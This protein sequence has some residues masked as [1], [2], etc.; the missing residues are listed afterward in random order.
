MNKTTLFLHIP[1]TGGTTLRDI[2]ESQYDDEKIFE[3]THFKNAFDQVKKVDNIEEYDIIKGHFPFG[4]HE[5]IDGDTQYI[6]FLRNPVKRI[7]SIYRYSLQHEHHH[8]YDYN[9]THSFLDYVKSGRNI[10][11][12][13]GHTRLLAGEYFSGDK[14]HYG[15]NPEWLLEKAFSNIETYFSFIGITDEFNKSIV[16]L[17]KKLKWKT[18]YYSKA[19]KSKPTVKANFNK[20]EIMALNEIN[21]LD[22]ALYSHFNKKLIDRINS[23]SNLSRDIR[24]FELK[25]KFIGKVFVTQ[26]ISRLTNRYFD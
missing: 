12:N 1:R 2:I 19:N 9:R 14:I 15:T 10:L 5:L 20:S 17:K 4:I 21:K 25:N 8:D 16:L 7:Q 11:L 22:R 24:F 18:P 6:T 13:N 23:N 3:I 26:R